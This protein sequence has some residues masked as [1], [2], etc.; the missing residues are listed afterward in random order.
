MAKSRY[1]DYETFSK[2]TEE[3]DQKQKDERSANQSY[4]NKFQE[5]NRASQGRSYHPY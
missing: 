1:N 5:Q 3:K 4:W 2:D